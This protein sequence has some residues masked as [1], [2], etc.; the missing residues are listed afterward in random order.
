MMK[1]ALG[2]VQFGLN[3]GISNEEGITSEKEVSAILDFAS[4][5]GV[6]LIDT[7]Q[8]YGISEEV[9]GRT[10][11]NRFRIVTKINPQGNGESAEQLLAKSLI[12][13]NVTELYGVLFHNAQSAHDNPQ[14]LSDLIELKKRGIVKK[15]G[16]SVYTPQELT[17]LLNKYGLP[18]LIQIPYSHLDRRFE[19]IGIELAEN[20]VEIH[21]RSTFLQG[22]FFMNK[23][24]LSEHFEPV[25]AYLESLS[26]YFN[27]PQ[28]KAGFLLNH[29]IKQSFI[30]KVVIGVNTTTQLAMNLDSID[31]TTNWPEIEAPVVDESILLPYFWK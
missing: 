28:S 29:A 5:N 6:D 2:A 7:A 16:Y 13:L 11:K 20:G 3:Y 25:K 24:G 9:L 15:I 18:D 26:K 19:K 4:E 1:L 10:H 27:D 12:R 31:Q 23:D 22:L 17:S 30:E 14:L 21:S 8:A